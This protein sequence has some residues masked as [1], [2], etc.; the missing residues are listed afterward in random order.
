M[1]EGCFDLCCP[2]R[3]PLLRYHVF[4]LFPSRPRRCH[5][6]GATHGGGLFLRSK[7]FLWAIGRFVARNRQEKHCIVLQQN[8]HA[9]WTPRFQIVPSSTLWFPAMRPIFSKC[10]QLLVFFAVG[11]CMGCSICRSLRRGEAFLVLLMAPI[12]NCQFFDG[13]FMSYFW[14]TCMFFFGIYIYLY[15]YSLNLL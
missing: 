6:A 5:S 13:L 10:K 14:Y 1:E 9:K 12:R 11:G 3:A 15:I 8:G 2:R 4:P 7:D